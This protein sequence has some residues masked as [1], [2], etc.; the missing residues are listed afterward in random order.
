MTR[1]A[2]LVKSGMGGALGGTAG[3]VGWARSGIRDSA[4]P[5][6]RAGV[7]T[8]VVVT[9]YGGNDGLAT[10]IP[11]AD[12][13]YHDARPGLSYSAEQVHRLDDHTGLS[14][15]LTGLSTLYGQKQL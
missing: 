8:L 3:G 2:F 14:P 6:R 15:S 13:A 11:Y 9:L 10:V 5:D 7:R 4:H 12:P 1:R